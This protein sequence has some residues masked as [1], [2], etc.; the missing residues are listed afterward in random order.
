MQ[1]NIFIKKILFYSVI[2]LL[3]L[4]TFATYMPLTSMSVDEKTI[5]EI[6]LKNQK[7]KQKKKRTQSNAPSLRHPKSKYLT[8]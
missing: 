3:K 2:L 1:K 4:G 6:L 5:Q 7:L 8:K